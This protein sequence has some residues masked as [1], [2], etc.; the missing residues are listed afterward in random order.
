MILHVPTK[1]PDSQSDWLRRKFLLMTV[2]MA[3]KGIALGNTKAFLFYLVNHRLVIF[4]RLIVIKE[5][6]NKNHD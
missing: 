1:I 6:K 5:L 2:N 3:F 4:S